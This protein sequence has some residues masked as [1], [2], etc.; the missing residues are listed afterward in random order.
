MFGNGVAPYA[1]EY[2]VW[3]LDEPIAGEFK[4]TGLGPIHDADYRLLDLLNRFHDVLIKVAVQRYD[5]NT[6][7]EYMALVRLYG[8]GPEDVA[9]GGDGKDSAKNPTVHSGPEEAAYLG[10]RRHSQ[11]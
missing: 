10:R 7:N 4:L 9:V 6:I 11:P 8:W 5:T 1:F 3:V 2:G